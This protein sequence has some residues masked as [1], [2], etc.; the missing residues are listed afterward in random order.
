M[1]RAE[2]DACHCRDQDGEWIMPTNAMNLS[3][4]RRSLA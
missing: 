4:V 1:D 3:Q 2:G